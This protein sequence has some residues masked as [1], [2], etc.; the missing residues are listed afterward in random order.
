MRG[1]WCGTDRAELH[2]LGD[3]AEKCKAGDVFACADARRACRTRGISCEGI[4]PP[5]TNALLDECVA[6]E[7]DGEVCR[8][9]EEDAALSAPSLRALFQKGCDDADAESCFHLGLVREHAG[10]DPE[11]AYTRACERAAGG[12]CA[13]LGDRT[14]AR[15]EQVRAAELYFQACNHGAAHGCDAL[16]AIATDAR[17]LETAARYD[18]EVRLLRAGCF[19]WQRPSACNALEDFRA[20][21]RRD[22]DACE[23]G[24]SDA[25]ERGAAMIRA[26]SQGPA[27]DARA[28]ALKGRSPRR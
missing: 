10:E 6:R 1:D 13:R 24:Q 4:V 25:C 2:Y 16:D 26:A 23:S 21:A 28:E 7:S 12:A 22:G 18:E 11:A 9:L 17:E 20:R 15:G 5:T 8:A 27:D 14:R 19:K 3:R